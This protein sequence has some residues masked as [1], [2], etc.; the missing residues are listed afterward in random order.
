MSDGHGGRT[1]LL[2]GSATTIS[3]CVILE[4]SM[5]LGSFRP[6]WLSPPSGVGAAATS[7][8]PPRSPW[9]TEVELVLVGLGLGPC[10]HWRSF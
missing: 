6:P 10:R 8:S 9:G 4:V 2:L 1:V 5:G 3:C 7:R